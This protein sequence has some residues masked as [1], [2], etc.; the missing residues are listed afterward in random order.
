MKTYLFRT[1]ATVKENDQGKYGL[2]GDF[3]GN[4]E[5][6]AENLPAALVKYADTVKDRYYVEVSKTAIQRKSGMFVN[7]NI[8]E[9]VQTGYVI[10]GKCDFEHA[11]GHK[12]VKKNID[13][14]VEIKEIS[15]PDFG[16]LA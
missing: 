2:D 15:I 6:R 7:R 13:L 1:T 9:T 11:D 8:G 12:W 5:V 14:W 3:I 4:I 16:K 10:N